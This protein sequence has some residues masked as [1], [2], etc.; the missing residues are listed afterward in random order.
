MGV[1]R[2]SFLSI[3][4]FGRMSV[5]RRGLDIAERVGLRS[6]AEDVTLIV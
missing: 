2:F 5:G 6:A 3:G 1:K 4:T